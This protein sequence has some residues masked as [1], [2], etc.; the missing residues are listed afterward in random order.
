[1]NIFRKSSNEF[2]LQ[3]EST[4]AYYKNRVKNEIS[5]TV[6]QEFCL[7]SELALSLHCV[8]CDCSWDGGRLHD[9]QHGEKL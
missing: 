2:I 9:M 5:T 3:S 1:M 4:T 8:L 7:G 6:P